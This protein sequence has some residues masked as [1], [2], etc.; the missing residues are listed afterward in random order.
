M[1]FLILQSD[2]ETILRPE[3]KEALM[4]AEAQN[5]FLE[6]KAEE[7][8]LQF[9]QFSRQD[10]LETGLAMVEEASRF[11]DPAAVEITL[12]G[13][14]IFRYFPEGSI[15]DNEL[16]LARKRNSVNLMHM[17]SLRF[18]YWLEMMEMSLESRRIDP[19]EYIACGG[20]YPIHLKGTGM[21]G[22]ICI[23]GLPDHQDDHAVIV[24]V[25]KRRL[26]SGTA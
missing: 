16:W 10:A 15:A 25:L 19:K 1:Q 20:G 24:A 26:G 12:N 3:D 14:V 22:S 5:R 13:L 11:P 2:S 7:Q 21:V 8:Q 9:S 4:N 18:L 17:S 6:L 23:S